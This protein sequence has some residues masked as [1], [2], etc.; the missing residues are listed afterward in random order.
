MKLKIDARAPVHTQKGTI[1]GYKRFKDL[2]PDSSI[3]Y[4]EYRK[5]AQ[6]SESRDKK[7]MV[8]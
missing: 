2:Y 5:L 1:I 3:T 6:E 7:R 8:R 4:K